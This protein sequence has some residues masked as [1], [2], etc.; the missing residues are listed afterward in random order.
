M[1]RVVIRITIGL[2]VVASL[3][4]TQGRIHL[5]SN[6]ERGLWADA[7]AQAPAKPRPWVNLGRQYALDGADQLAEAAYRRAMVA[8]DQPGRSRDE[9]VFGRGL[10][11]ANLALL[12]AGRGELA[13]AVALTSA[14]VARRTVPPSQIAVELWHIHLQLTDQLSHGATSASLPSS[15]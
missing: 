15:F 3:V 1:G 11:E 12:L 13:A 8:A 10:A 2:W 9:Q 14:A 4:A 7:V 5:W 6:G